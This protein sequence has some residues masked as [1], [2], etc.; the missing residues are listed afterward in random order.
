M[1]PWTARVLAARRHGDSQLSN[2]LLI[3]DYAKYF[4]DNETM[5]FVSQAN[6]VHY[7]IMRHKCLDDLLRINKNS[8]EQVIIFG[9]GFDSKCIRYA[10]EKITFL[11]VDSA[12]VLAL[13]KEKLNALG[14]NRVNSIATKVST[15][16]DLELILEKVDKHKKTL[17]IAEGFFPYLEESFAKDFLASVASYFKAGFII[18]FDSL[19]TSFPE[20][21]VN[22]ESIK[23]LKSKSGEEFKFYC[24]SDDLE[25]FLKKLGLDISV[26]TPKDLALRYYSMNWDRRNDK[27]IAIV[28][29][30]DFSVN[31]F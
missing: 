2:A 16:D 17:I 31:L 22:Q 18:G 7:V 10:D 6:E 23:R 1:I 9:C 19:C 3:D 4:V 27:Y 14:Y 24:S 8:I 21:S 5:N 12:E 29:S 26:Y 15:T 11:E 30:P 20:D 13:K 25:K 28:S